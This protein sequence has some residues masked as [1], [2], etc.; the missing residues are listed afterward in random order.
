MRFWPLRSA[1][2]PKPRCPGKWSPGT[3][4]TIKRDRG[5]A[6]RENRS[7]RADSKRPGETRASRETVIFIHK[8]GV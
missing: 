5:P 4:K 3:L 8:R 1:Q 7:A 6:S 2:G